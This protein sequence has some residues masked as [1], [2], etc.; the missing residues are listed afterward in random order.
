M[1]RSC[2]YCGRIHDSKFDCGMKPKREKKIT[3]KDKFRWST[4]WK[5]KREEIRERDNNLCQICIRELFE[6]KMK[7]TYEKLRSTSCRTS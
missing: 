1:L 4:E 5:N 7:Y 6:T 3:D 2:K